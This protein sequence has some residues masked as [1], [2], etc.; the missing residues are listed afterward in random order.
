MSDDVPTPDTADDEAPDDAAPDDE[1]VGGD[2]AP[3]ALP[4]SL[5]DFRFATV[6]SPVQASP[7]SQPAP[8][9]VNFWVS[10]PTGKTVFCSQ[11]RVAVPVGGTP[12]DFC[13]DVPT[14]TPNTQWWTVSGV[15]F[16]DGADLGLP[17]TDRG[18]AIFTV[19]CP[20]SDHW[21]VDY[22][23]AFSLGTKSMNP[24]AGPFT[25]V[26]LEWSGPDK[27]NLVERRSG[28]VLTKADPQLYLDNLVTM[29]AAPGA[30][31]VPCTEFRNGGAIRLTWGSNGSSFALYQGGSGTPV[32]TGSD[33]SI[34]VAGGI[35]TD[36]TFTVVA[37]LPG[38]EG[39]SQASSSISATVADPT[40]T[41]A[42]DTAGTVIVVGTTRLAATTVTPGSAKVDGPLTVKNPARLGAVK[43]PTLT[44]T[45]NADLGSATLTGATVTGGIGGG[46][47]FN[48]A[49]AVLGALSVG[50]GYQ[51]L[52]ARPV[53]PGVT[54][55]A[56]CDG[57]LAG[58]VL[59]AGAS[60][61]QIAT[62]ISG[63]CSGVGTVYATGGNAYQ[64]RDSKGGVM[65]TNPHSFLLPVPKGSTFSAK[66]EDRFG[67]S[68][69][70]AFNWYP[71]AANATLE[72]VEGPPAGVEAPVPGG[73]VVVPRP[74]RD[75]QIERVVRA[76]VD[77]LGD[78]FTPELQRRTAAG[79]AQLLAV[80]PPQDRGRDRD[81][82]RDR[83]RRSH[84]S[85]PFEQR[86][87]R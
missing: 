35:A 74:R 85:D 16:D 21:K 61:A 3:V 10:P 64:W 25:L 4:E 32:W 24:T 65:W 45:G 48:V 82:D 2:P 57:F 13:T 44:V 86:G 11:F 78:A 34:T 58:S 54:Y 73:P 7:P 76:L 40:L 63:T 49:S 17:P 51:G 79:I 75:R 31:A 60:G 26:V 70:K 33:T 36:T 62:R 43:A 47:T 28:F 87:P 68:A 77:L 50:T 12:I 71:L 1:A 20:S 19:I 59:W 14:L 67:E 6:P 84:P 38:P 81:R 22:R 66:V 55:T 46:T 72:V 30:R 18:Y 80:A 8:G 15:I 27:E 69:N 23:L 83:D 53:T 5:F 41:P 42:R 29:S 39:G 56:A 9:M 37:T 52:V